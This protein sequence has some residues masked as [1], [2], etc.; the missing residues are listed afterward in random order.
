MKILIYEHLTAGGDLKGLSPTLLNEG[1]VMIKALIRDLR[2]VRNVELQVLRHVALPTGQAADRKPGP[3]DS[4]RC[5][6]V[7]GLQTAHPKRH[8][9]R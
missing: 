6:Q 7:C 3:L 4:P 1:D 9:L 8:R 2:E 5:R